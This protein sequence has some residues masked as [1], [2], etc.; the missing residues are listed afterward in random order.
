MKGVI[1]LKKLI[2]YILTILIIASCISISAFADSAPER[3]RTVIGADLTEEQISSVYSTF[4]IGRGTVKELTMTNQREREELS[5][6]V[7]SAIIGTKSI[8]C[9]FVNLPQDGSGLDVTTSENITWCTPQMYVSA[10]ATAGITDA[11]IIVTAP[12]PV[13]GTAAL[14][15]VFW[16]YE[17][18]TGNK[19]DDTAKLIATQELTISG[20]LTKELGEMDASLIINDLKLMLNETQKMSDEEIKS[21]IKD[22]ANQYGVALT[23][24]QINKLIDLCRSLEGLDD[25][26]LLKRVQQVQSTLNTINE[27]KTK[28]TGF[29]QTVEKVVTSVKSF[30]D[31]IGQIIGY[32]G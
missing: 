8:S 25:D 27:T 31:K 5:G 30:F 23:E 13:S 19:L 1:F 3:T 14:S 15:G 11:R 29:T 28:I 32:F 18:I 10:L 9:V 6:F 12:F 20:D 2:C 16:A 26:S 22:I 4:A 7:D 17:D 21:E 24:T